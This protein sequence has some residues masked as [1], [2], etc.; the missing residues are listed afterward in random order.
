[1][2]AVGVLDATAERGAWLARQ[3]RLFS[4]REPAKPRQVDL[5]NVLAGTRDLLQ[6]SAG[7][8]IEVRL[9]T[10]PDVPGVLADPGHIEQVLLNLAANACDAMPH[11]GTLTISTG[12]ADWT[13]EH[14]AE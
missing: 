2:R 4:R 14:D 13:A 6:A 12:T 3:L 11:G 7:G 8:D 5:G 9:D 1:M 10:G